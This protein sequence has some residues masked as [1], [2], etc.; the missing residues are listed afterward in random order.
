MG[1]HLDHLEHFD[2]RAPEAVLPQE[3]ADGVDGLVHLSQEL[4]VGLQEL[5]NELVQVPG[6]GLVKEGGLR[7]EAR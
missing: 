7:R 5:S 2:R 6:R 1:T 3:G 4:A